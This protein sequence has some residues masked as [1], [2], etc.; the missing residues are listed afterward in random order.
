MELDPS[1][2]CEV[3]VG[4]P[5]VKVLGAVEDGDGVRIVIEST[6]ARPAC[7]ECS[8][9]AIGHG[10]REVVLVDLPLLRAHQQVGVAQAAMALR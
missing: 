4:L 1:R 10:R 7:A 9:P 2:V 8:R 5:D 3:L 6:A